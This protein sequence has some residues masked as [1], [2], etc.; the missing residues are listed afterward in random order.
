MPPPEPGER[1]GRPAGAGGRPPMCDMIDSQ[2]AEKISRMK[3]LRRTLS[4]SFG[5]IDEW[6]ARAPRALA[7]PGRPEGRGR[8]AGSALPGRE[9]PPRRPRK[10]PLGKKAREIKNSG[11]PSSAAWVRDG[12]SPKWAGKNKLYVE[13]WLACPHCQRETSTESSRSFS[14]CCRSGNLFFVRAAGYF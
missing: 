6:R 13:S 2:S 10:T 8:A 7:A 14:F 9:R 5:R 4:E 1:G 12:A 3:K 11:S